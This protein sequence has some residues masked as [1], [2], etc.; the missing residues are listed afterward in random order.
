MATFNYLPGV[1]IN[2]VDGGLAVTRTPSAQSTLIIGTAGQG[3][4]NQVYQVV[5]QG[6]AAAEFGYS[7]SLTRSMAEAATYSDNVL[8]YRMGTTAQVLSDVGSLGATVTNVVIA[9]SVGTFTTGAAHGFTPGNTVTITITGSESALSG[10]YTLITASG[11][12][13]TVATTTATL[14]STAITGTA[15]QQGAI[16]TFSEV[17]STSAT[18]YTLWYAAGVL[19]VWKNGAVVYSN[20]ETVGIVDTGDVFLS[21][22]PLA[23]LTGGL[24]LGTS[25]I[26]VNNAV[27]VAVAAALSGTTAAPP[28]LLVSAVTGLGLTGRQ[29]FIAFKEAIDLL[30]D[31]QTSQL[32]VPDAIL[33]AP[34]VAYYVSTNAAATAINNPVTNPNALDWLKVTSNLQTGNVY[35]WASE[36][37]N[38]AGATVSAMSGGIT[39][40]AERLAAGWHEVNWGWEIANLAA[41]ISGLSSNCQAFIGTSSPANFSLAA[42][43]NW[44]GYLPTYDVNGNPSVAGYGLLGIAYL[45]GTSDSAMNPLCADY[46]NGW[47]LPGFFATATG[48]YDGGAELD[49]N[50]Y[51]IDIGAYL[52]VVA[53]QCILTNVFATNYLATLPSFVAGYCAT[54]DQKSALTYKPVQAAQISGLKY[55]PSQLDALTQAKISVLRFQGNQ[56]PAVLLHDLT[57]ATNASDYTTVSRMRI[58]GLAVQTLLTVAS[59]YVGYSTN[60]GLQLSAMKT[61]LDNALI[62][63]TKRGYLS[64]AQVTISSTQ[65]QQNIGHANLY[66]SFSPANE[67][68]QLDAYVSFVPQSQ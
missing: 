51:P 8:L 29:L 49:S 15:I 1:Q 20:S 18:D 10:V 17:S 22:M 42:V 27:T 33:D 24:A 26:S 59:S 40:P 14:A 47:R 60:D 50:E 58:K 34:N 63:L 53:D 12:S 66:L 61:A 2:T 25:T 3:V 56:Q 16:L 38:S 23:N 55:K 5:N 32:V 52:H 68:I 48:F 7:G 43:R 21:G 65:A 28:P 44:V 41:T 67:L 45:V 36:T 57:C 6:T 35:Q 54:L 46:A 4:A 19:A 9:T 13:F 37:T 30:G 11:T 31:Y 62:Q 64:N 39:T